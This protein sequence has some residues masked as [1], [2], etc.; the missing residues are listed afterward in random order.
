M[1]DMWH[2]W[3]DTWW[4]S[5]FPD[6]DMPL[7]A[8][9]YVSYAA[10]EQHRMVIILPTSTSHEKLFVPLRRSRSFD[11][12]D[13]QRSSFLELGPM[14]FASTA[15]IVVVLYLTSTLCLANVK[16]QRGFVRLQKGFG[17]FLK[18]WTSHDAPLE[19]WVLTII[20]ARGWFGSKQ[21]PD[22]LFQSR[23]RQ[24]LFW[25]AFS[26]WS[27]LFS[28]KSAHLTYSLRQWAQWLKMRL[29]KALEVNVNVASQY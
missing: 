18:G 26:L 15:Q 3:E 11:P 9:W 10:L 24:C 23:P 17:V 16:G 25:L 4:T 2:P 28:H 6:V 21:C 13:T 7:A 19:S 20:K 29:N 14:F 5:T 8:L 12:S 27:P 1:T 22:S